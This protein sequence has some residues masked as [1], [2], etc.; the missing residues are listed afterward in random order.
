MS[1][2]G[3]AHR[4]SICAL[5]SF[6]C[7]SM[8]RNDGNQSNIGNHMLKIERLPGDLNTHSGLLSEQELSLCCI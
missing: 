5:P 8:E 1:I 7:L 6:I 2:P 4:T 3:H